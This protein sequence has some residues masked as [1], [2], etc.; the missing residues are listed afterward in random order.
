MLRPSAVLG[1]FSEG[2]TSALVDDQ[3]PYG[4]GECQH[5]AWRNEQTGHFR[6]DNLA[7]APGSTGYH[8]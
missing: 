7:D 8:G 2:G 1:R 4:C 3:A 6:H 5:I